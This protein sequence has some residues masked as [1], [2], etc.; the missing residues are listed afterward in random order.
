MAFKKA[1]EFTGASF[2]KPAEYLTATALLVEP[3]E[4]LR[5][6][7]AQKFGGGG[8]YLRDEALCDITVFKTSEAAEGGEPTEIL[9]SVKITNAMLVDTAS[10][11]IGDQIVSVL[12]KIPTKN[13]SG[14]V[15]RDAESQAAIDGV[16]GHFEKREAAL[17]E[18]IA[19]APS[20][21]D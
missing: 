17:V 4:H 15:F 19:A 7:T 6:Q 20:F 9:K 1:S 3:V 13:G 12:K 18:A 2:F 5:D 21:D 11:L 8:T 14:Y 16:V 10:K